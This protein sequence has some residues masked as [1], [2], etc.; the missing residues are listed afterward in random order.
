MG[1]MVNT[2][3]RY[4]W[5]AM[6]QQYLTSNHKVYVCEHFLIEEAYDG[7][8]AFVTLHIVQLILVQQL[9]EDAKGLKSAN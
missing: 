3:M 7:R 8:Q 6:H 1:T 2:T 4:R 5:Q 9:N